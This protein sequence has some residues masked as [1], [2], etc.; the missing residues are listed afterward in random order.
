MLA[1]QYYESSLIHQQPSDHHRKKSRAPVKRQSN[2]EG[3]QRKDT[4]IDGVTEQIYQQR[5]KER[6]LLVSRSL[7]E[8]WCD[9]KILQDYVRYHFA[10][11]MSQVDELSLSQLEAFAR[12]DPALL[13]KGVFK[14][15]TFTFEQLK[16]IAR[17]EQGGEKMALLSQEMA[18]GHQL[19]FYLFKNSDHINQYVYPKSVT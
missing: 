11:S 7:Y 10:L 18:R 9:R 8:E 3:R 14:R 4:C 5:G 19:G 15:G 1:Y 6:Q 17:S 16:R 2:D 13:K 12:A